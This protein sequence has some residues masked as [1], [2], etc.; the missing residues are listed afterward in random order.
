MLNEHDQ[1]RNMLGK[2]RLL[3]E[4]TMQ[5]NPAEINVNTSDETDNTNKDGYKVN[6]DNINTV[7]FIKSQE[8]LSDDVKTSVT[9]A[10]GEFLKATGLI[11]DT[12]TIMVDDSHVV[13]SSETIKNPG[14]D[15]IKSVIFDTNEDDP[16]IEVIS[17]SIKLDND[18]INL[19]QTL[20]KTFN[21]N[22]VG[23]NKLVSATQGN[24]GG[25]EQP[26]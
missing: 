3:K 5:D 26:Q 18:M 11:L 6:F 22:Q 16:Q 2:I 13:L 4:D 10:V 24:A 1:I 7:G 21:D 15:S 23:K 8:K 25:V 20:T 19:L 9:T 14:I 12:V 17:G